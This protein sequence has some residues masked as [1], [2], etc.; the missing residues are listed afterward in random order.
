MIIFNA[1]DHYWFVQEKGKY[2]S[3]KLKTYVDTVPPTFLGIFT[4]VPT[5][6]DLGEHGPSYVPTSVYMW[7]AKA[8]LAVQGK[9]AQANQAITNMN[10]PSVSVAWEYAS[11][12]SR[13]SPAVTFIASV[14]GLTSTQVDDLFKL[15]NTIKV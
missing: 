2:W 10:N 4:S 13:E 12:I 6:N 15:A 8:A 3:S 14:L 11:E 1:K 9:L 5:E 7:Q